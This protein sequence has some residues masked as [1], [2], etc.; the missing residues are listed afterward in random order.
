MLRPYMLTLIYMTFVLSLA[1]AFY[2]VSQR[3]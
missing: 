2:V 3:G 1:L